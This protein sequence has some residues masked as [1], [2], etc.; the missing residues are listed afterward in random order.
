MASPSAEAR[1]ALATLCVAL[2]LAPQLCAVREARAALPPCSAQAAAQIEAVLQSAPEQP[3]ETGPRAVPE[4]PLP[5]VEE[6]ARMERTC[7]ALEAQRAAAVLDT[8]E[9]APAQAVLLLGVGRC[10]QQAQRG[11]EAARRYRDYL[12]RT[13][14]VSPE[15]AAERR[16][17]VVRWLAELGEPPPETATLVFT[18]NLRGAVLRELAG[19]SQGLVVDRGESR[20]PQ[21]PGP[22]RVRV[23]AP[24]FESLVLPVELQD[25]REARAAVDFRP[26]LLP[27]HRALLARWDDFAASGLTPE[28]Y[29]AR[30]RRPLSVGLSLIAL[31]GGAALIG[32]CAANV[33]DA[34]DAGWK[35]GVAY[36]AGSLLGL[37]GVIGVIG[38]LLVA[39]QA[40][41]PPGPVR[42]GLAGPSRPY[43]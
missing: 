38:A 16:A 6:P 14:A 7:G 5:P 23:L 22:R 26:L 17:R 32:V 24:G 41:P 36:G 29:E 40:M 42:E 18:S 37:A 25:A 39:P 1:A 13:D 27:A 15:R 28:G 8:C 10:L 11:A 33:N 30:R 35:Q 2:C 3:V 20:I 34:C 21:P 4:L 12:Q 31:A 19:Y 9:P 43:Y